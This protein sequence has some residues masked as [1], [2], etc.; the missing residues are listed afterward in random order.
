M[1]PNFLHIG[2][3]KAASTW[4]WRIFQEHP[5]VCVPCEKTRDFSGRMSLPDHVNFFLADYDLGLDWYERTYFSHW[6]GE[7]AVG[8]TSNSYFVS[9][10][11]LERIAESLPQ[12]RLSVT[13]RNPIERAFIQF[14]HR[15]RSRGLTGEQ[16]DFREVLDK[17][18][19][20][21]FRMWIEIGFYHLHLTRVLRLFPREQVLVL[22][23]DDLCAD[24]RAFLAQVFA[25]LDVDPDVPLPSVDRVVGF[26]SPEVPDSEERDLA[27]GI[28]PDLA[29]RLSA[30]YADQISKLEDLLGRDLSAWR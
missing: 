30:I 17:H 8:E 1:L 24:P 6:Q 11:A 10:L 22:I 21:Q 4:L 20:Q 16:A 28:D 27:R 9:E 23:Y 14:V 2:V 29:A 3:A 19:W 7:A 12:V 26:P 18:Q 15:K 25:F 5:D 13:L